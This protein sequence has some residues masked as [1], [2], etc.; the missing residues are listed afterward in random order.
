MA[1]FL[2]FLVILTILL[3]VVTLSQLGRIALSFIFGATLI[4]GAF[5]TI[6]HRIVI[7]FVIALAISNVAVNLISGFAPSRGSPA[8]EAAIKLACFS[9]LVFMTI[10]RTFRP[11]PVTVYRIMG[12]IAGYLLIGFAWTFAY[13]LVLHQAPGA[14]QFGPTW[15]PSPALDPAR[16]IYFSF[17]T[18]T[19]VGYG[20]AYPA[21]PFARSLAVSEALIGQLYLTI[22]IASLVGMALQSKAFRAE[23]RPSLSAD[24]PPPGIAEDPIRPPSPNGLGAIR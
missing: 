1:F 15:A 24:W 11:G 8:L 9:I 14:I 17:V 12:G 19:T 16:L 13:Q 20:D 23:G 4:F 10:K 2:A 5:A 22:L 21:H 18:L 3:P 7:Y 6:R